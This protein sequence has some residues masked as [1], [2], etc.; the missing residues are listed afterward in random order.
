[1]KDKTQT[2][3]KFKKFKKSFDQKKVRKHDK[4]V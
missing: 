3:K 4:K 1:M 2:K